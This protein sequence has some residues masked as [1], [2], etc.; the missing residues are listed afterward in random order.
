MKCSVCG[1]EMEKGKASF[2][3]MQGLEPMILSFLSDE[4]AKKGFFKRKSHDKIIMSGTETEA[5]Y[6]SIC[7]SIVAIMKED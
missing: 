5:Y 6:C 1:S 4:E 7:K 3:S 2:S